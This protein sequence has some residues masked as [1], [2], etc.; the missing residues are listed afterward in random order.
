MNRESHIDLLR[1]FLASKRITQRDVVE[2]WNTT[3][4]ESAQTYQNLNNKL[5]HNTLRWSEALT[6][7]S[8]YGYTINFVSVDEQPGQ[9]DK[10]SNDYS[11]SDMRTAAETISSG[12]QQDK[13]IKIDDTSTQ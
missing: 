10:L 9:K 8:M 2:K 4:P 3:Y 12:R 1:D 11:F 5:R 6:I 13:I 7:L